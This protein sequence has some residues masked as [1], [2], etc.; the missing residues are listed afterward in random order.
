MSVPLSLSQTGWTLEMKPWSHKLKHISLITPENEPSDA[1]FDNKETRFF[2][3]YHVWHFNNHHAVIKLTEDAQCLRHVD[4]L[5]EGESCVKASLINLTQCHNC[6]I[7]WLWQAILRKVVIMQMA[8]SHK[9]NARKHLHTQTNT[10]IHKHE[11][12]WIHMHSQLVWQRRAVEGRVTAPSPRSW[13]IRIRAE[14]EG[15]K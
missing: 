2:T 6:I 11:K 1:H 14:W 9:C 13:Q 5:V 7:L 10:H 12:M 4:N 3:R 15:I 8:W